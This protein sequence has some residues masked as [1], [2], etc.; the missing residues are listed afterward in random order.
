MST[1]ELA[2]FTPEQLEL[3]ARAGLVVP[4]AP[5]SIAA[6]AVPA[7]GRIPD[8]A[9]GD[10]IES[11]WGNGVRDRSVPNY[12]S[13][14]AALKADTLSR[15]AL[16]QLTG[17]AMAQVATRVGS[18][19]FTMV[20]GRSDQTTDGFGSIAILPTAFGAQTVDWCNGSLSWSTT[21][22]APA[23]CSA[24]VNANTAQFKC[25]K[26]TGS[27]VAIATSTAVSVYYQMRVIL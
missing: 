8:V 18:Q 9:D 7:T 4:G 6:L 17:Q 12:G 3:L 22:G 11:A 10:V 14:V 27:T 26:L 19:W 21:D 20:F 5:P 16:I 13:D 2:A 25:W 1:T 23:W 15:Q 24:R